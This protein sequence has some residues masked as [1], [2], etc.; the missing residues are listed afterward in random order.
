MNKGPIGS[1]VCRTDNGAFF[2]VMD[3]NYALSLKDRSPKDKY[4]HQSHVRR[5][6]KKYGKKYNNIEGEFGTMGTVRLIA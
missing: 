6:E 5:W 2:S 4:K 3:P 1:S